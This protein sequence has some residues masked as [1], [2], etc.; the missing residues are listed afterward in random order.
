[1]ALATCNLLLFVLGTGWG[2][3]E[4]SVDDSYVLYLKNVSVLVYF[5]KMCQ[6]VNMWTLE[7]FLEGFLLI[8][9][10]LVI[11]Q[12]ILIFFPMNIQLFTTVKLLELLLP[13]PELLVFTITPASSSHSLQ[14]HTNTELSKT[15][16]QICTTVSRD[17]H[18]VNIQ[19]SR[20]LVSLNFFTGCMARGQVTILLC[21]D[22][23]FSDTTV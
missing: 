14:T 5:T 8:T 21:G 3:T 9:V 18:K 16:R 10:M 2:T 15:F 20:A 19:D 7:D 4:L 1:M 23:L 22:L 13:S 6:E 12:S 11:V 17:E